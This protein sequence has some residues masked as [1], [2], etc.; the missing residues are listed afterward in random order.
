MAK[1]AQDELDNGNG[2]GDAPDISDEVQ[3]LY[4]VPG[5]EMRWDTSDG[6]T[7]ITITGSHEVTITETPMKDGIGYTSPAWKGTKMLSFRDALRTA[8]TR[9]MTVVVRDAWMRENPPLKMTRAQLERE[10]A[11]LL[12]QIE[13]IKRKAIADY[14]S[15]QASA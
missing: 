12:R 9:T 6:E 2:N 8:A 13:E 5:I 7:T 1:T 10:H 11:E 15:Q 4:T 14:E 3:E